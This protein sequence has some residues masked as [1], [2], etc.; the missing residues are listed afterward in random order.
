M[1]YSPTKKRTP[2]DVQE[3]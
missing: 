2:E 3:G 1:S